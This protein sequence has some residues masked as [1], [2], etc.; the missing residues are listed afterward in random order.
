MATT[1]AA[2]AAGIARMTEMVAMVKV[3]WW[4]EEIRKIGRNVCLTYRRLR[5]LRMTER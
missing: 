5:N 1:A 3:T 4:Q 2:L